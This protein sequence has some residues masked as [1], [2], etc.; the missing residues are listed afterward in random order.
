LT[1]ENFS[2]RLLAV[3]YFK[4]LRYQQLHCKKRCVFIKLLKMKIMKT[5]NVLLLILFTGFLFTSCK[6]TNDDNGNPS[7]NGSM[8]LKVDGTAWSASLSVQA[9]NTNGV[10]NITG[11]DSKAKQAA[12]VLYQATSTGTYKVGPNGSNPGNM[13]RWTEGTGQTDT[14]IANNLL[15][16][17]T[18]TIDKLT[19][20]EVSGTFQFE[21]YSTTQNKKTITEGSFSAKF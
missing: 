1:I 21:G 18:V 14:Y 3:I 19:A 15:G 13:L 8:N 5:R 11:S 2:Q 12:V 9:V 7:G 6:K 20:T 17:G 4:A 10:I 16:S